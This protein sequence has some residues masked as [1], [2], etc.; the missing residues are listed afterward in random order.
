MEKVYVSGASSFICKY[1]QKEMFDIGY[2]VKLLNRSFVDNPEQS[3]INLS[4]LEGSILLFF[5]WHSNRNVDYQLSNAN[6]VWLERATKA[7]EFAHMRGMKIVIPGS[8]GEYLTSNETPY[9]QSK[10]KLLVRLQAIAG[11]YLW[12]RIFYA[13]S[14]SELRPTVMRQALERHSSK[15]ILTL[16]S[17]HDSQDYIEVRDAAFQIAKALQLQLQGEIDIGSGV[18]HKTYDLVKKSFPELSV[19]FS[20]NSSFSRD[21]KKIISAKVDSRL[22]EYGESHTFRYFEG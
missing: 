19:V 6:F 10:R 16:R 8:S 4:S 9:I 2:D 12:P 20:E 5:G 18:I 14:S 13:F 22:F 21:S 11:N 1:V 7:I 17:F 3:E 15:S